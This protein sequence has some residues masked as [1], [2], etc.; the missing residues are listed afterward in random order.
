MTDLSRLLTERLP[1]G[2]SARSVARTAQQKGYELKE[3]TATAYFGGRHGRVPRLA[4]LEALAAVLPVTL[5]ELQQAAGLPVTGKPWEP[6]RD[7]AAVLD[8][9][10]RRVLDQLLSVMARRQDGDGHAQQSAPIDD[11]PGGIVAELHQP[12]AEA[13]RR[14]AA[15]RGDLPDDV[16]ARTT[17]KKSRVQQE[18]DQQDQGAEE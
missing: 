4:T 17:G 6:N 13:R 7:H 9:D 18:R 15:R 10:Q 5:K 16:A 12:D 14:A 3:S 8:A 11:D 1:D 2:M